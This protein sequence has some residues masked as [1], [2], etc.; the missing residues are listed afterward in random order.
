M[1][2]SLDWQRR[3]LA[4][5]LFFWCLLLFVSVALRRKN[6]FSWPY[7]AGGWSLPLVLLCCFDSHLNQPHGNRALST[8][9][10][11]QSE[12]MSQAEKRWLQGE[13]QLKWV[14]RLPRG[15]RSWFR[16]IVHQFR[17]ST[18]C[19]E[20]RFFRV[21]W[22]WDQ[23]RD[24]NMADRVHWS[25]GSARISFEND[26]LPILFSKA[27]DNDQVNTAGLLLTFAKQYQCEVSYLLDRA[28]HS[29]LCLPF[30]VLKLNKNK[31]WNLD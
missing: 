5:M 14:N 2:S 22:R 18:P 15:F 7:V 25:W 1:A 23:I 28:H 16:A 8:R 6:L 24:E 10:C 12:R 13:V 3:S 11:H 4:S 21:M 29:R 17:R 30:L 27:I 20:F 9:L 26:R 19:L 31:R